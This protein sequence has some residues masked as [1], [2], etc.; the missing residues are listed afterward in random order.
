M[1]LARRLFFFM[2]YLSR[3]PWDTGITPPEV[4]A[5]V[6]A[7]PSGR[8]LDL[9]C[10]TGTNSVYLAKHGW[11]VTGVDFI[12]LAISKARRKARQAGVKIEFLVGDVAHLDSVNGPFGLILDIG[13]LHSL[14]PGDRKAY[15]D[16]ALHLL[17]KKGTFLLYAFTRDAGDGPGLSRA[18][19]EAMQERLALVSRQDGADRGRPSTWFTW[20]FPVDSLT[21]R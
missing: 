8:A 21:A 5:F 14:P 18:D 16:G 7:H 17:E 20:K 6:A 13:C 15:L 12:P 4:E 2:R 3:P 1:N 11:R 9:G 19:L 10:G